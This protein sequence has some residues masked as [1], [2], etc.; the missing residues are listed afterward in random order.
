MNARRQESEQ[1]E[2]RRNMSI[3]VTKKQKDF[4]GDFIKNLDALLMAGEVND[5][6]IAIDDAIIETFDEDGY[7]SE[8]GNQLQKIYDEIYGSINF[9]GVL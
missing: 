5:L 1:G 6:L 7:P 9:L 4:L 2:T 8:T 3:K